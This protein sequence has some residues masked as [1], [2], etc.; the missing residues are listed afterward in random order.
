LPGA[1]QRITEAQKAAPENIHRSHGRTANVNGTSFEKGISENAQSG[2]L[3]IKRGDN[4][5]R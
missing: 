2:S 1:V 3:S 5:R 4:R